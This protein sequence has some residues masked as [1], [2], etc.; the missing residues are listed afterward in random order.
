MCSSLARCLDHN[1]TILPHADNDTDEVRRLACLTLNN[2]SIPFE[3]KAVMAFG[4]G[5]KILLEK[6]VQLIRLRVPEAYLCC[7]CLMNLSF[8]DD[9]LDVFVN[10]S[11][12]TAANPTVFRT[13]PSSTNSIDLH[14][15]HLRLSSSKKTRNSAIYQAFPPS[16]GRSSRN[17]S[18]A[19]QCSIHSKTPALDDPNSLLR[20]LE[21]LLQAYR[22][23]LM[24]TVLSI[25]GEAVRWAVALLRNLTRKESSCI[26]I[27]R[28]DIPPLLVAI[29][30]HSPHPVQSWNKDSLEDHCLALLGNL[31]SCE[32][33]I[34]ALRN[35]NAL[36]ALENNIVGDG[37]I[38][39][40]RATLVIEALGEP[41]YR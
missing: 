30:R 19:R 5:S 23:F 4:P 39:D 24:S 26:L 41:Q 12:F 18:P 37:G 14:T 33:G 25:E 36:E 1:I 7:I 13:T 38:Y 28:T 22:P 40:F 20:V 2:L 31:I 10:Y 15:V 27:S 8:L 6:L 16:S 21:K 9:A 3:N 11:P 35:C 34:L 29:L 32:S 17:P